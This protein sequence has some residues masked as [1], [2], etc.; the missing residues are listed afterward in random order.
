MAGIKRKTEDEKVQVGKKGDT[1]KSSKTKTSEKESSKAKKPRTDEDT[2]KRASKDKTEKANGKSESGNVTSSS[3]HNKTKQ[4]VATKNKKNK[5]EESEDISE[6][7]SE[8]EGGVEVDMAH[9]EERDTSDAAET[10]TDEDDAAGEA[11]ENKN[12]SSKSTY[13]LPHQHISVCRWSFTNYLSKQK[14]A[15]LTFSKELWRNRGK[16]L[17]LTLTSLRDSRSCGNV[18]AASLMF[19]L[20]S[21]RCFSLNCSL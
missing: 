20:M 14:V 15:N 9:V 3:S 19:L 21:G 7:E 4:S 6:D 13:F 11:D 18:C 2:G 10:D 5:K 1:K 8:D 12:A 16:L 17:N